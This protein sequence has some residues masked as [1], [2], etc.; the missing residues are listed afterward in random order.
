MQGEG[1][2][3][4]PGTEMDTEMDKERFAAEGREGATNPRTWQLL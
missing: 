4:R 2:G 3:I 1:R